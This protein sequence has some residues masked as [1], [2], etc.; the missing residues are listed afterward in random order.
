M[1]TTLFTWSGLI[2]G[3]TALLYLAACAWATRAWLKRRT[4]AAVAMPPI[5][6]LKPL[7]GMEADLYDN[8]RSFCTQDYPEF[9]IIF[10]SRSADDPALDVARTLQCEFPHLDIRI[11]CDHPVHCGNFKVANLMQMEP[12]VTSEYLAISDSDI[13]VGKDYLRHLAADLAQPN[14]GVVTCL[15]RGLPGANIWSRLGALHINDWFLPSV[16]T[17]RLLGLN[18]FGFGATLALRRQSLERIGGFKALADQLAD[19]YM[20]A[21]LLRDHGL[22][23]VLSDY[24][25]ETTVHEPSFA[26]LWQHELR[27]MRTVRMLQPAGHAFSCITH[28]LPATLMAAALAQAQ[29]WAWAMPATALILRAVMHRISPHSSGS[30][31]WLNLLLLPIRD[32]LSF[33][34]W[35]GSY[36]SRHVHWRGRR[37]AVR[38][39]GCMW[40]MGEEHFS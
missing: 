1:T 31:P 28:S 8:L 17:G 20:L 14:T 16:L 18:D 10:G 12:H 29:P 24:L 9:Q 33:A 21:K 36:G 40:E 38:R 35:A 3:A 23:T 11:V 26:S 7:C 39:D 6:I 22:D 32:L 30:S 19:D 37:F 13:R 27:W 2:L 25:V 4:T 5:T 34:V 15:Y